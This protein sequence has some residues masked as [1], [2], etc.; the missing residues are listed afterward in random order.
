MGASLVH[1]DSSEEDDD[2]VILSYAHDAFEYF[3]H[4]EG[5]TD[6]FFGYQLADPAEEGA[7]KEVETSSKLTASV[8]VIPGTLFLAWKEGEPHC[9]RPKFLFDTIFPCTVD[10]YA[11]DCDR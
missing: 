5:D 3:R 4:M 10:V 7:E 8:R 6:E 11:N 9:C 1:D 2:G